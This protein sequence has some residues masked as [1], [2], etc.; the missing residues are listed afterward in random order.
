MAE[1]SHRPTARKLREARR[2]G[3]VARSADLVAA[4]QFIALLALLI[5]G[6]PIGLRVVHSLLDAAAQLIASPDPG[7]LLMP[8]ISAAIRALAM[9][10]LAVSAVAGISAAAAAL[11]QV[12]GLMAWERIRPD[13]NRLNPA[14]GLARMF[15]LRNLIDLAKQLVK[16]LALA[17]IIYAVIR[18]SLGAVI[19][20]GFTAPA[21]ILGIAGK[22]LA[23]LFG[24]AAV[25]YAALAA[26]DYAH[27]R[28]QHMRQLR[29]STDEIRRE[30]RETEGDPQMGSRRTQLARELQFNSLQDVVGSASAV[31]YS[32]RVA[33]ALRYTGA[34]S[35][36]MVVARGEG[37]AAQR[38]RAVARDLLRPTVAN[39]GLA[40]TL[41]EEVPLGHFIDRA[42]F[43]EVAQVLKWATG[44]D[45]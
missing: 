5:G 27:Q 21:H 32:A 38:I 18:G 26:F 17:A 8:L 12:G 4:V 37:E 42:H 11:A 31:V 19:E 6:G 22:L 7:A 10:V 24:W 15:S 35:L 16:T 43:R 13:L 29:M 3:E 33:V 9:L 1:K 44:D 30:Y 23:L 36:P 39:A 45:T 20:A 2:K 40:E 28:W 34:P 41:Y 25:V 14:A